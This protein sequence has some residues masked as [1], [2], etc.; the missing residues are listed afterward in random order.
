MKKIIIAFDG[1][2][3]SEGA[4][5]MAE[6]LNEGQT[7]LMTGVFLS[8]VDYRDVIGYTGAGMSGAVVLPEIGVDDVPIRE[9]IA[10][11]EEACIRRGFEYRV[12][13]DTDFFALQELIRETRF[14]DLMIL[15]GETFYQNIDS[16]QPNE[17]LK[18]TL[19]GSECPVMVVPEDFTVPASLALAYDGKASSVH[20]LKQFAYLFPE[21]CDMDSILVSAEEESDADDVLLDGPRLAQCAFLAARLNYLAMDRPDLQFSVKDLMRF[22]SQPAER[23][24]TGL[25]R[26]ARVT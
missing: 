9:N 22:L 8:P 12:H 13:R 11:F 19:H 23:H 26:A 17:Y 15:S 21:R 1:R 14:A 10:R 18:R 20:A 7:M 25:K 5:R 2:N 3:F 6:W 24:W 4:M 16:E